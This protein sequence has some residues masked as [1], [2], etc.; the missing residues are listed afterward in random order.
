[1]GAK[2]R[3]KVHSSQFGLHKF[4]S[5][6]PAKASSS[7]FCNSPDAFN[8]P[9]NHPEFVRIFPSD[10]LSGGLFF[11]LWHLGTPEAK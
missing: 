9:E 6:A 10:L 3:I 7:D 1:M 11:A 4:S 5:L 8:S 2:V